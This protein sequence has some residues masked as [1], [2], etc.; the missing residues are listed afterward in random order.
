MLS[1][2]RRHG[3]HV[4]W[5]TAL[6]MVVLVAASGVLRSRAAPSQVVV[7]NPGAGAVPLDGKWQ[8]HL[9]DN[10]AWATPGLDDSAW[11]QLTAD[12]PWGQ[13]GHAGYHGFAWYR[14]SIILKP[15]PAVTPQFAILLP[16]VGQAYELY[17]NGSLV[18][19]CG[20]LPP[21]PVWFIEQGPHVF[22]LAGSSSGVLALR[23]WNPPPLSDEDPGLNGGFLSTPR[24]GAPAAIDAARDAID[25]LWLRSHLFVFLQTLLYGLVAVLC[26]LAWAWNRDHWVLFWMAAFAL[27]SV[28]VVLLVQSRAPI[29]YTVSM[30]VD[31]PIWSMRDISIWFLLLWILDLRS[32]RNLARLTQRL[33]V[34]TVA[35]ASLDG[36]LVTLVWRPGLEQVV[37]SADALITA[38]NIV[39]Q[40]FPLVLVGAVVKRRRHL[41]MA[42]SLVAFSAFLVEM[43]IVIRNASQ[44][45][46]R[47]THWTLRDVIDRPFVTVNGSTISMMNFLQMLLFL[48]IVYAVYE[49]FL[50]HRRREVQIEHELK[51]AQELQTVLLTDPSFPLPG[52]IL[53]SAYRPAQEVGGD[54]FQI[55]PLE[56]RESTPVL[57]ILG[58]VSGKGLRAAM[59]VSFLIGALRALVT[60]TSRPAQLLGELNARISGH[61]R[62]ACATCLV[63][64]VEGDG[65]CTVASAGHPGPFLDGCELELPGA[66]P[67]GILPAVEYGEV[68]F[69]LQGR[70]ACALYTDGLVEARNR[71][72][73]MY[74]FPR[75]A[76]M[77][78]RHPS[79]AQAADSA[80][81]FGQTDDITVVIL[82]CLFTQDA[83]TARDFFGEK[84][85][86]TLP[87][88]EPVLTL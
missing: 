2:M 25:Y 30:A 43:A 21:R 66:L 63:L 59:A 77:F 44:Q 28:L 58:D 84:T 10:R 12:R 68:Q 51:Q 53:S 39:A 9:G 7:Q 81:Y 57:I 85:K 42:S 8:F 64:R 79:A 71:A 26:I 52:F 5:S 62:D 87:L 33:A 36:L 73:Q 13:Q 1:G 6:A 67:I 11:E 70:Q 14:Q 24:I 27:A 38:V 35:A 54:F 75:L 41:T 82:T 50:E 31:Q 45:G 47:F 76:S 60:P 88:E 23:V 20:S 49:S 18:G 32:N 15:A 78:G 46:R 4:A 3:A 48:C 16:A 86:T 37:Q 22:S 65:R 69:H 17:W 55:I 61:L 83:A 34:L 40:L 56:D 19:Q 74:G 72:G 80:V 29:P